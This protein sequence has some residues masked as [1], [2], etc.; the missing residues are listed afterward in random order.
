MKLS[1]KKTKLIRLIFIDLMCRF[2]IALAHQFHTG[3]LY[4]MKMQSLSWLA[5]QGQE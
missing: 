3:K 2:K 5:Q 4:L 1:F